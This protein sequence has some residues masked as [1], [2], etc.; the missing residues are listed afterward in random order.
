MTDTKTTVP[1]IYE[2]IAAVREAAPTLQKN[3]TGPSTQG[4]YKF[5]SI[6]DILMAIR[7]LEV[8]HGIISFPVMSDLIIHHNT[9]ATKDDGR[10]PSES[11]QVFEKYVFRYLAVGDGTYID[12]PVT[13]EAIDTSDK[14]VRKATTQAQKI[15]NIL[16]YNLIT[17]DPDPD[18]QDGNADANKASAPTPATSK[19]LDAAKK[20]PAKT[21]AKAAAP[22]PV[23]AA[24]KS[25]GQE[26]IRV[27]YINAGLVTKDEANDSKKDHEVKGLKGDA[28]WEQVYKDMAN[29][30][31]NRGEDEPAF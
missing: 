22:A 2:K 13:G 14:A 16:I 26:K 17:G 15:A 20:A 11:T 21:P 28:L 3:G 1:L 9:A 30:V 8:E 6:D 27:E 29:L 24:A 10:K 5:L 19:A 7:P 25:P 12:V 23:A 18:G 4:A 31:K